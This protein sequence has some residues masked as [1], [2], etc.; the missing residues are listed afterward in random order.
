M[1]SIW[2]QCMNQC[3][4]VLAKLEDSETTNEGLPVNESSFSILKV[5]IFS[6]KFVTA[7]DALVC[8]SLVLSCDVL[9]ML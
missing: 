1:D 8:N 9:S 5:L 3:R 2:C 7:A 6:L 4:D